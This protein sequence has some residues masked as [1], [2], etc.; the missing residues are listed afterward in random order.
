MLFGVGFVVYI[1]VVGFF[2]LVGVT[3]MFT[4]EKIIVIKLLIFCNLIVLNMDRYILLCDV[5]V[6]ML[7]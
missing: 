2:V 3:K 4:R 7:L 5:V 1:N 6:G